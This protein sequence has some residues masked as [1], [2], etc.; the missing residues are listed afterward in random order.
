MKNSHSVFD[1][2]WSASIKNFLSRYGLIIARPSRRLNDVSSSV[3]SDLSNRFT[4]YHLGSGPLVVENYLNID[5]HHSATNPRNGIPALVNGSSCTYVLAH[6]LRNGIPAADSSL[7]IIYHSHFLE[8]L[9]HG[10]GIAFLSDCFR[11]LAPGATMRIALPDFELWC[12]NYL[13]KNEEFL[14]WYQTTYL[15]GIQDGRE[16]ATTFSAMIYGWGHLMMYDYAS[17]SALLNNLGF[18][19]IE[20]CPW[21]QSDYVPCIEQLEHSASPRRL[22]SLVVECHTPSLN[23]VTSVSTPESSE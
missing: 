9:S 11:C 21:G 20:C 12:R 4:W 23:P 2:S 22:E 16:A 19:G 13:S 10:D 6:D 8:H 3:K 7:Q 18:V 1:L 5:S 17:L 15:G 14:N